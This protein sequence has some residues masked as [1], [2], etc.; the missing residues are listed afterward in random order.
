[1][2]KAVWIALRSFLN[3][4]IRFKRRI[5]RKLA[6]TFQVVAFTKKIT[7]QE[8]QI[9][10]L[11]P[12]KDEGIANEVL[13]G[14]IREKENVEYMAQFLQKYETQIDVV[15]DIGSNIGYFV[16]FE[17]LFLPSAQI[18]AFEPVPANYRVLQI[19]LLLNGLSNQVKTRQAALVEKD[20]P[21][22]TIEMH[23]PP[24]GNWANIAGQKFPGSI[25]IH[26]P[27]ITIDEISNE[28]GNARVF[29]RMDIEGYEYEVFNG[30]R[31]FLEGREG[32]FVALEFHAHLLQNRAVHFLEM[33]RECGFTLDKA[34]LSRPSIY[35]H[36]SP[37]SLLFR[38]HNW[39]HEQI[40]KEKITAIDQISTIED[41]IEYVRDEKNWHGYHLY[42]TNTK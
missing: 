25:T 16:L 4:Y 34:I 29:I 27:F 7:L 31:A 21:S 19:N 36:F 24:Q 39:L 41:L 15:L 9:E 42:L 8:K 2:R 35:S 22:D 5:F 17:N 26:V 30:A 14:S 23:V 40:E 37:S 6:K 18:Y 33:L 1:M 32:V 10:I 11:L 13:V 38:L 28:I 12:L 3:W 20:F